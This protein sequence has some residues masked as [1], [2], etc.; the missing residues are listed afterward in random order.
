MFFESTAFSF[1]TAIA[2][3]ERPGQIGTAATIGAVIERTAKAAGLLEKHMVTDLFGSGGAV[4]S[5]SPADLL[6]R[7][8]I[9]KHV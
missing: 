9:I 2:D 1:R 4:P 8:R 7:S 6:K 3:I 5:R